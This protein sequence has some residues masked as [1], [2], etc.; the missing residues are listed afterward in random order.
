MAF[1]SI[2][3]VILITAEITEDGAPRP[4]VPYAP[5]APPPMVLSY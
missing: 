3:Q 1:V 4:Y 5:Y 2:D